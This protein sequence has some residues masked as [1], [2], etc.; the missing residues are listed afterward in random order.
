MCQ[1]TGGLRYSKYVRLTIKDLQLGVYN[2]SRRILKTGFFTLERS[3]SW[4]SRHLR[5]WAS[6]QNQTCPIRQRSTWGRPSDDNSES[7]IRFSA[8]CLAAVTAGTGS[9]TAWPEVSWLVRTDVGRCPRPFPVRCE[10][11]PVWP[12]VPHVVL[13]ALCWLELE[14]R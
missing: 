12:R 13:T 8:V 4:T 14:N 10:A 3:C 6:F 7:G 2:K 11:F 1:I 5:P 9:G